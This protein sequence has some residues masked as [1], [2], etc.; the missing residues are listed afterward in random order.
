MNSSVFLVNLEGGAL[1][2]DRGAFQ[3]L[4]RVKTHSTTDGFLFFSKQ[5]LIDFIA[6]LGRPPVNHRKL[7]MSKNPT[8]KGR[9]IIMFH[10]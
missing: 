6:F 8:S 1:Q 7:A 5:E 3:M 2:L 9:H 4:V 10:G